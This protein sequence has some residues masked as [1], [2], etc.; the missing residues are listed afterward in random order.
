VLATLEE[1]DAE[2]MLF[3]TIFSLKKKR[4]VYNV[5]MT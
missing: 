5:Y 4:Y 1:E 3:V 2:E